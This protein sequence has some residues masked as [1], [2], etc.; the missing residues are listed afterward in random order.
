MALRKFRRAETTD[1]EHQCK[2]IAT[3]LARLEAADE[4]VARVTVREMDLGDVQVEEVDIERRSAFS[5]ERAALLKE[6]RYWL[7][8]ANGFINAWRTHYFQ[9]D[10]AWNSVREV[11]H[12]FCSLLPP[13][14]LFRLALDIRDDLSYV[15]EPERKA[16]LSEWDTINRQLMSFAASDATASAELRSCRAALLRLSLLGGNAKQEHWHRVNL[17]RTRLRRAA[18]I[19]FLTTVALLL[20]LV[21]LPLWT[22]MQVEL[23]AG[24]KPSLVIFGVVLFGALGGFLSAVQQHEPLV[25]TSSVFY[26]ERMFLWLRP[27][28]GSTAAL[29][30]YLAQISH[31]IVLLDGQHSPAFYWFVAFCT[32]FSEKFF[33]GK[34]DRFLKQGEEKKNED[35]T[36]AKNGATSSK[37]SAAITE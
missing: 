18:L 24:E 1:L 17:L 8:D 33:L 11:R 21:L 22:N 13:D 23:V 7:D 15:D 36:G 34:L 31:A 4:A 25:G 12:R 3:I 30:L 6:S 19:I 32:G 28:V 2:V 26:R 16:A 27:I 5:D 37:E 10:L 35:K 14:E 20:T 29:M 9:L